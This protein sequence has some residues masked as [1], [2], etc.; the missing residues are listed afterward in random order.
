MLSR[1]QLATALGVTPN[2]IKSWTTDGTIPPT[3]YTL[4]GSGSRSSY[5]FSPRALMIG[6]LIL[7][8][9]HVF[10]S[11]NSPL[12]KKIAAALREKLERTEWS[13]A[14]AR[15]TVTCGG[16]EIITDLQFMKT[17]KKKLASL[18]A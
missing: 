3:M 14:L 9:N 11:D 17:A 16:F 10:G 13:D 15:L 2:T 1:E 5:V 7:E 6:E 12:P 4:S 8:L 18:A